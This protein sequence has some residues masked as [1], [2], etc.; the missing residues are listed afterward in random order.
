MC[1]RSSGSGAYMYQIFMLVTRAFATP[2][3]VAQCA[4]VGNERAASR[5]LWDRQLA[6]AWV[7]YGLLVIFCSSI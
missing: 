1:Q 2:I 7:A 5:V 4:K 3:V 6:T